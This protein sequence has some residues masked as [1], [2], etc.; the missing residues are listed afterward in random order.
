MNLTIAERNGTKEL[1]LHRINIL[2]SYS[3]L[4]D[5]LDDEELCNMFVCLAESV[6]YIRRRPAIKKYGK[7]IF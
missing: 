1:I 4:I 6:E 3:E 5:E 7:P 2:H